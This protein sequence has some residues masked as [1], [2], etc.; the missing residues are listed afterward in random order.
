MLV[1]F[2]LFSLSSFGLEEQAPATNRNELTQNKVVESFKEDMEQISILYP[3]ILS[4][5]Q[6]ISL[7]DDNISIKNRSVEELMESNYGKIQDSY[8]ETDN[9]AR[10]ILYVTILDGNY[11]VGFENNEN[12]ISVESSKFDY[13]GKLKN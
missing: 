8:A 1:G 10:K 4:Q 5:N 6:T 3:E 11:Q 12:S 9:F 7:G 2:F 13:V